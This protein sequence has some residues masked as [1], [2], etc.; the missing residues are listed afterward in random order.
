MAN[1]IRAH[2]DAAIYTGATDIVA[3][4][5]TPAGALEGSSIVLTESGTVA[6]LFIGTIP[7]TTP[8]GEY[9]VRIEDA[10]GLLAAS[11]IHWTGTALVEVYLATYALLREAWQALGANAA[12][13]MVNVDPT[14]DGA[15]NAGSR[16]IG[17]MTFTV[18]AANGGTTHTLQRTD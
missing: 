14:G 6:G 4:L 2:L 13:P 8:E 11:R 15:G 9:D 17:T 18:T 5:T 1:E 12:A 3:R 7:G 16:T 10:A